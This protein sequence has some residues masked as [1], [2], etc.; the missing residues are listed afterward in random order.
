MQAVA[1][2]IILWVYTIAI[3][4]FVKIFS[5]ILEINLDLTVI[6]FMISLIGIILGLIFYKIT[7]LSKNIKN[8]IFVG[9][10]GFILS[11]MI[12]T[13][14]VSGFAGLVYLLVF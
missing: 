2:F 12:V 8:Y 5:K 13:Y 10:P 7:I 14:L 3:F 11:L 9:I 4:G 1:S 6:S